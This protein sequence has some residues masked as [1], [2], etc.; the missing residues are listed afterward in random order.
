MGPLNTARFAA[1]LE[2]GGEQLFTPPSRG[3]LPLLASIHRR[4]AD[5]AYKSDE[6]QGIPG[7]AGNTVNSCPGGFCWC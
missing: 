5:L 6:N 7:N 3:I 4:V 1:G 2:H